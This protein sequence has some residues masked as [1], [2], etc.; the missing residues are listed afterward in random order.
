MNPRP[1]ATELAERLGVTT[2]SVRSYVAA[3]KTAAHPLVIVTA[4][5]SGYR[6]NREAYAEF[7]AAGRGRGSAAETPQARVHHLVRRLTDA[8]GGLDAYELAE[9][10]YVSDST[11]EADLRKVKA[12]AEES[13]ASLTRRGSTIALVG[14]EAAS[15]RLLS[16]LLQSESAQG[17]L[18]LDAIEGEFGID[19][20]GAFKTELIQALDADGFFINEYGIDAV[21]L[22]VAIAVERARRELHLPPTAT[23]AT[24]A[25]PINAALHRL[26]PDHFDV[27]VTEADVEYLARLLTTRVIAPGAGAE[28]APHVDEADLETVRRIVDLVAEEYLVDFRDDAFIAR[29]ALHLGNL[30][31]RARED[32]RSRNPLARSIKSSYPLIFDIAVFIASIVQRERGITVDDDEISYIALHLGSHLERVARREE[33]VTGTIICPSYYDLHAILRSRI[34]R[35]LGADLSIEFVVTRTDV[36][37]REL[38]SD[39]VISTIPSPALREGV[40]VVQP[41]LTD[42]DID[43]IRSAISRVRRQRR[44]QRITDDLLEYF[45]AELFFPEPPGDD[46]ESIIRGLGASLVAAGIVDDRYVEGALE[47]ERMSSTA[48]SETLAMPHA[49]GLSAAR[50]AIALALCPTPVAWGD[51]RVSV[52][53]LIAFSPEGRA[54]FQPLFDQ[55]V[56]VFA[57]RR[58]VGE[59][60]RVGDDFASFIGELAQLIERR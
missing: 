27:A 4:S 59:L 46:P 14:S 6:L 3:A 51:A 12:L 20:L 35:E 55:F 11:L 30:V 43:A 17:V 7:L 45:D 22:H 48:F 1:T 25:A 31:T 26:I 9:S 15:R 10:L 57:S 13:G 28:G 21:I 58:E 42:D 8:D 39:L 44:R 24:D 34:E 18:E 40:V 37:P 41:F 50:T 49:M 16:R 36:D 56:D 53:A 32:A 60:V 33:R 29:L 5:T 19:G 38:T 2:R 47:R 23:A 52:V 54:R